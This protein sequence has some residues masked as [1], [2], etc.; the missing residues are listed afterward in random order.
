MTK[1]IYFEKSKGNKLQIVKG[2]T[3]KVSQILT[4]RVVQETD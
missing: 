4:G 2:K 3:K 1:E